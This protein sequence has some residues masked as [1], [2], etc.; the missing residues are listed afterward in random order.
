MK[1]A[2][3]QRTA[4]K[5][6]HRHGKPPKRWWRWNI[7]NPYVYTRSLSRQSEN[8]YGKFLSPTHLRSAIIEDSGEAISLADAKAIMRKAGVK[9]HY[10][11]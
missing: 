5:P 6:S 1:D 2:L 7:R 10:S 11:R 9:N 3:W 8:W 4:T